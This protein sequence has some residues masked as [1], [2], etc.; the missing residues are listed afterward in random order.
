VIDLHIARGRRGVHRN[1]RQRVELGED[2]GE[3]VRRRAP[4]SEALDEELGPSL[5]LHI[6]SVRPSKQIKGIIIISLLWYVPSSRYKWSSA[7]I[8][9]FCKNKDI[10]IINSKSSPTCPETR[11]IYPEGV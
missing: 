9:C 2:G 11:C 7:P 3:G 10:I 5:L 4:G 1:V 8:F 6:I